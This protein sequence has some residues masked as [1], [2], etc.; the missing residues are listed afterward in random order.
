MCNHHPVNHGDK[1]IVRRVLN[2]ES[3]FHKQD[4]N[5]WNL[6]TAMSMPGIQ[7]VY[8]K[9]AKNSL[10]FPIL[11]EGLLCYRIL[12]V[13]AFLKESRNGTKSVPGTGPLPRRPFVEPKFKVCY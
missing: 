6:E 7:A 12:D 8:K 11:A 3:L 10:Q 4:G 1:P 2:A 9:T 13:A 5:V